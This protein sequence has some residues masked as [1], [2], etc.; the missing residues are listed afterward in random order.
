MEK[1][2]TEYSIDLDILSCSAGTVNR[3]HCKAFYIQLGGWMDISDVEDK[4]VVLRRF[5]SYLNNSIRAI[6]FDIHSDSL[7]TFVDMDIPENLGLTTN[8][9]FFS[10]ETT[11]MLKEPIKNFR[12]DIALEANIKAFGG[13]VEGMLDKVEGML[14][15]FDDIHVSK[16]KLAK[17]I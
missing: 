1:V 10:I 14:D 9:G 3:H 7:Y 11:I 5:K 17:V 6:A 4:I 12:T 13:L 16:R 2:G 8:T 15:K